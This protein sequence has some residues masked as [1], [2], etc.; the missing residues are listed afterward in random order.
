VQWLENLGNQ[1]VP[2]VGGKNAS[3]GEMIRHLQDQG[4]RVP[5]GFA[6][7]AEAYRAFVEHNDLGGTLE[8]FTRAL[9]QGT[10]SLD[11]VGHAIRRGFQRG[12]FPDQIAAAI[13]DAYDELSRRYQVE[14]VSVAVRS[15]ATAEDLPEA[16]FAGQQETFLDVKGA[17]E[18]MEA[19]RDCYASLFTNRAIAYRRQHGFDHLKVAL[20]VG[21][22]KMVH[23]DRAGAGV[24]FSLD[25]DSGFPDVVV[26]DASWGLGE[27]VVQGIVT[28]D[29]YRVFKPRLGQPGLVP[30]L[31]K[32]LGAKE[33][34][35][36]AAGGSKGR[37][38]M[39]KTPVRQR[40]RFVLSDDEIL[41]LARWAC[42]IEKHYGRPMDMEWAKDG[43]TGE[44]Y[45]VQARPETIHSRKVAGA[46]KTYTLKSQAEPIITGIAIGQAI[47]QGPV[48]VLDSPAEMDRFE[49]GD[50]LV[51]ARTDPDWGPIM[52]RAAA[53]V[54]DHGGRTSHAAIVSRELGIPAVVGTNGAT[55]R[56]HDG[57]EVTISCAGGEEGRIYEG[58]LEYEESD[59]DITHLA[60]PPVRI[61]INL[62]D[63]RAALRWWTLPVHGVGLA[64]MEF[65]INSAIKIHPLALSRFDQLEDADARRRIKELTAGYHDK[66]EYFVERLAR[67]IAMIAASQYP[68]PVIVRMSDFKTN[69]YAKLIGGAQFEP[70]EE[71]PMLGFRGA[72]RYYSD[73]YKDGFALECRAVKRAREEIGL[74]NIVVMIPFVRTLGEADRVIAV[75]AEHGLAR[76]QDGLKLYMM[77]EIPS[78]VFL[79]ESFAERFDG[80]SIGSN[81]LT[82]LILGV[83]RD[84]AELSA[85]FDERNEAVKQA[86]RLVIERAHSKGCKVGICGQAPSDY[87]DFARFLVDCGIDSISLN[88]DSVIEVIQRLSTEAEGIAQ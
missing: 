8:E 39:V 51:T 65:I 86:I 34:K 52:K 66:T 49:D 87:P 20:S 85:L 4:I 50:V 10:K 71:N 23:A 54:T 35:I 22:Q 14:E 53:I 28:P 26:I 12:R 6:T 2:L 56:L 61:M 17:D 81:D 29:E 5:G 11:E 15:S 82:Q 47:A 88:P 78:N 40:R 36:I 32:T 55:E 31:E 43:D 37:T 41:T 42:I 59:I 27:T 21:V 1:D 80:F 64:R 68:E 30:I 70:R 74:D 84:S 72:S 18:L 63:P 33:Q 73:R 24:M 62:A 13:R 46:L 45:C 75:M 79:A 19:C 48:K 44:L 38:K 9:D 3:L 77:C 16:S 67:G 7:T 25:T 83:D 76:G 60:E 57:Q 58:A 69:E